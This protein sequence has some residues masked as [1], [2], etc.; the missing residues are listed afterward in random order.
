MKFFINNFQT[1]LNLNNL[2]QILAIIINLI[3]LFFT[4]LVEPNSRFIYLQQ[5]I[6]GLRY[7]LS[8]AGESNYKLEKSLENE[9][10]RNVILKDLNNDF[11]VRYK[12]LVKENEQLNEI[13]EELKCQN[14]SLIDQIKSLDLEL[15]TNA[16]NLEIVEQK[17]NKLEADLEV[18]VADSENYMKEL[19]YQKV[20]HSF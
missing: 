12:M 15:E 2:K 6:N 3:N 14:Q 4:I 5:T 19:Q 7:K 18:K 16:K 8:L 9:K 17:Y 10:Q 1:S 13:N 11:V 20:S